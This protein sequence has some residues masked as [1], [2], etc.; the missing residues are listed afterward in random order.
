VG[1]A[2]WLLALRVILI[3]LLYVQCLAWHVF[4]TKMGAG[5]KEQ[6]INLTVRVPIS[7]KQQAEEAAKILD[8]TLS[9]IVRR[10]LV[11][12]VDEARNHINHK[13][14]LEITI[15]RARASLERENADHVAK[16]LQPYGQPSIRQS[17]HSAVNEARARNIMTSEEAS[18][19]RKRIDAGLYDEKP[20]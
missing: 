1:K 16:G 13:Q 15:Q 7:L 8:V 6:T 20:V 9:Q 18:V 12:L 2:L 3:K 5:M 14:Y 10:A 17:C 19:H 4:C 11:T